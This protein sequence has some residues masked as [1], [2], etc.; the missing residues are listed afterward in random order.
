[1]EPRFVRVQKV[2]GKFKSENIRFYIIGAIGPIRD[3]LFNSG[4]AELINTEYMFVRIQEAVD[5]FDQ[6]NE[7]SEL[8]EKLTQQRN[9]KSK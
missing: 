4:I 9:P 7:G 1:M 3:A 5:H 6:V 8:V 2:I